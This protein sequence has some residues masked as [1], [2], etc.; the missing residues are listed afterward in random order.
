MTCNTPDAVKA[1]GE[2]F[3]GLAYRC[4]DVQRMHIGKTGQL[5][6]A[7]YPCYLGYLVHSHGVGHECPGAHCFSDPVGQGGSQI[8]GVL[9]NRG[10]KAVIG[11]LRVHFDQTAGDRR[12]HSP[13]GAGPGH[14]GAVGEVL[15]EILPDQILTMV[16]LGANAGKAVHH[17]IGVFYGFAAEETDTPAVSDGVY[18]TLRGGGSGVYYKYEFSVQGYLPEKTKTASCGRLNG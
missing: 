17:V 1:Q 15:P 12:K 5:G 18:G 6:N 2:L 3:S 16:H 4:T 7:G 9:I 14:Y 8:G 11:K 13:K 10:V